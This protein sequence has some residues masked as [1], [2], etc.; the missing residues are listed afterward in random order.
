MV[1]YLDLIF[2]LN[3]FSDA[4]SLYITARLSGLPLRNARLLAAS[5]LGGLYGVI[6]Y[7][8]FS[9]PF[10]TFW[11]QIIVALILVRLVFGNPKNYLRLF[12]LFL[13]LSCTLG[14]AMSALSLRLSKYGV[15][16]T[17][18]QLDWKVFILASGMCYFFL[19]VVFRGS[20]KHAVSGQI[21]RIRITIGD[22]TTLL[23]ALYDT[24]NTLRDPCSGTPVVTVWYKA[25]EALWGKEEQVIVDCL[26]IQGSVWCA[27]KL[28]E[29]AP[30]RF[31][32][33]PY[34]AVGVASAMLLAFRADEVCVDSKSYG[35]LT[36]ALSP[37][38][39]SDGGGYTALWGGER[40]G[41]PAN[42]PS[43]E[44]IASSDLTA[45]RTD[46]SR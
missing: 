22:Q 11:M 28:G 45:I 26:E 44:S 27:E 46:P 21:C 3:S 8:P 13:L 20:A 15:I 4:L 38:S 30:G 29:V 16:N 34:R 17:L 39:V 19:S 33:I 35:S 43:V 12:V 41:I 31:Y 23:D 1:V 18:Q 14:G 2:F 32:L 5:L 6:C 9:I 36:I 7:L 24:G 10:D 40:T 42:D 25:L 37:T